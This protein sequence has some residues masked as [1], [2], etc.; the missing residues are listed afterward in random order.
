MTSDNFR[1][2]DWADDRLQEAGDELAARFQSDAIPLMDQ[3][4]GGALRL[5]RDRD[6][7]EDL[8]QETMLRAYAGFRTFRTGTNLKAWLYR[9]LDNTWINNYRKQQRRPVEVS[10]DYITDRRLADYAERAP[11]GSHSA[12]IEALES[13]PDMEI[14]AEP[15][16]LTT[17]QAFA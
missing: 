12:E 17:G 9:I 2:V 16:S 15:R 1:T 5:T 4:F 13:L 7:A 10:V 11:T 3:L 8:V 6:D 14:T